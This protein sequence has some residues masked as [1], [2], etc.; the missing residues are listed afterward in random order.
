MATNATFFRGVAVGGG[1]YQI[2]KIGKTGKIGNSEGVGNMKTP[3]L[4]INRL[5]VLKC[6]A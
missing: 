5:N 6:E 3:E 4:A 1:L 2:G